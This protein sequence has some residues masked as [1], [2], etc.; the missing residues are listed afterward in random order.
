MLVVGIGRIG[1]IGLIGLSSGQAHGFADFFDQGAE[2]SG[3]YLFVVGPAI[4]V[5]I[6]ALTLVFVQAIEGSGQGAFEGAA[7][8]FEEEEDRR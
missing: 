2:V 1:R 6:F 8:A 4:F 7:I 3:T 5:F